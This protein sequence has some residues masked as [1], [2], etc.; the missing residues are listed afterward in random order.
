MIRF[1][2]SSKEYKKSNIIFIGL[3]YDETSS[4]LKGSRFAPQDV[5]D[6]SESI[7]SYSPYLDKDLEDIE[8]F[9]DGDVG[10]GILDAS[11]F[12]EVAET[13]VVK[14]LK[15]NKKVF[16]FGGEHLVSLAPIKQYAKKYEDL[17]IIHFDAHADLRDTYD[18]EKLSHATVLRRVCE[19]VEPS[20]IYQFGI[21]S[22]TREEYRFARE[23]TNF[24]P[25]NL[26][27]FAR[28]IEPLKDKPIYITLDLDILDPSIFT[29]TGTPEPGGVSF[30]ELLSAIKILSKYNIVGV[31]VVE[32]SP[33]HDYSKVS[34]IVGA[35]I[36]RELLLI[37]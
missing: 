35:K 15:D 26:D 25:T 36:I 31:D 4:F 5:R 27:N 37:L 3:P 30:N 7:E 23:N 8:F 18:G 24:F 17:Y 21:R 6:V 14:Y 19:V 28:N 9:D 13:R 16:C 10:E 22:G 33:E 1:F 2:C 29:G 32:L 20:K 34:S 11:K 12:L